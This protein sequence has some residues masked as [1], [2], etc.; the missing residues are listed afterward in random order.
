MQT[1]ND[2]IEMALFVTRYICTLFIFVLGLKAPGITSVV[3]EDEIHLVE[4]ENEVTKRLIPIEL[5]ITQVLV[6]GKSLNFQKWLEKVKVA[7]AFLVAKERF[8]SS[9][10]SR[11]LFCAFVLRPCYQPLRPDLQQKDRRFALHTK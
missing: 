6:L 10:K 4:Q 1:K 7:H 9:T 5:K 3:S 8:R 11:L 2:R